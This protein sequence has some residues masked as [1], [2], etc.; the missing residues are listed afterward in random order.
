MSA[1]DPVLVSQGTLT[2]FKAYDVR[3]RVGHD[4][5][6]GI[7]YRIGRAFA[8][9]MQ[10]GTVVLGRDCRASSPA[11]Q[12]ALAQG[13]IEGGVDVIDIG[14]AGTEEVYFATAHFAAGGG[15]E[16][17]ASHNPID[18][19]GIKLVGPGSR[20]LDPAEL[21]AI[22]AAAERADFAVAAVQG[23]R[24]FQNPR[25]AYAEKVCSFVTAKALR[26][27]RVLVNAGN[28]VAGPALDQIL[29]TLTRQGARIEVIRMHHEPDG[30]F[31][32]GI[33]NPLL[34]ENRPT[35]AQAVLEHK[36]DLGVAWDG[37]FDRCFLF[38]ETGRFID[39]EYIVGLLAA[40]F[41]VDAPGAGIVHDPRV[42]WNTQAE[43]AAAGGTAIL[44]RTGHA[45]I[46]A[47]MRETG[48]IY[49]GEM[50]AHHYF[51][52]F[53][54][55]DSG[56]IPWLKVMEGMS[57]MGLPLSRMVDRMR[58]AFPSSGERNYKVADPAAAIRMVEE[59]YSAAAVA[60]DRLDGL[61][62]DMGAWRMNLRAS[63]TE[64]LLRLN[65]ETR[66]D[67]TLLASMVQEIDALLLPLSLARQA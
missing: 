27:L 52:D 12:D 53:M 4:L 41:L 23:Q 14:I 21:H 35:T 38:D 58:A 16:V 55:C 66:A 7:A 51:R 36:A 22:R 5:D 28:G 57:V 54:A 39:G 8:D 19:N 49:G 65:I 60:I 37:D 56:M 64:P 59:T 9:V 15:M 2:C 11:L 44:A 18:Y 67:A 42:I 1:H 13:L 26:P 25:E 30:T 50:S 63:N 24:R 45:L 29:A 48:A 62:L 20:P 3:G 33:P 43:V 17:T 46:K 32:N 40:G 61:S 10:P 6:D 31:P 47:R 34:P